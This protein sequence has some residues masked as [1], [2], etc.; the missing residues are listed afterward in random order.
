MT[1][2]RGSALSI[3][4]LVTLVRNAQAEDLPSLLGALESAKAAAWARLTAPAAPAPAPVDRA[5][6]MPE[7]AKRLGLSLYT[8]REL[9]RKG[10]LPVTTIGR[11]VVVRESSLERYFERKERGRA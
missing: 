9:G 4:D 7:V 11:R 3:T 5:L 10:D 6:S 8:V 2:L 1:A